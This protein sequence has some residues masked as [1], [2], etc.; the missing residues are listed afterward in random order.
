[1]LGSGMLSIRRAALG[2]I[3]FD[4]RYRGTSLGEDIDLSWSLAARGGRLAIA[5]DAHVV[6]DRAGQPDARWEEP[7]LT[8]W[9][10]VVDKHRAPTLRIRAARAWFV[11]GV[12]LA[13]AVASA[14]ARSL[15]P[16]RSLRAGLRNLR[17]G[18][19]AATFLG[20]G[21]PPDATAPPVR[22]RRDAA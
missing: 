19:E 6:H 18:Y 5:T 21:P 20:P 2:T 17:H 9:G 10:F 15:A 1:M 14:R 7:L 16:L 3:R 22:S 8:S 4:P 13:A 12:A 11:A